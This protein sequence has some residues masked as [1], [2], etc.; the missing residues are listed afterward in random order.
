[1]ARSGISDAAIC[2]GAAGAAHAFNRIYQTEGDPRCRD[3]ASIWLERVLEMRKPGQ[4]VGGYLALTRPDPR[5]EEI[6]EPSPA[7][8][9]GAGGIALTLLAA[10]TPVEPEWDRLLLLSGR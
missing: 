2:H 4:G 1:M 6:W 10:L 9:D 5:S 3:A 7:F 8:L